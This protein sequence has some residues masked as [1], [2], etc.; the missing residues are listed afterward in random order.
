[1]A[2][3]TQLT[4]MAPALFVPALRQLCAT[5]S[6]PGT[7]TGEMTTAL[8]PKGSAPGALPT[9]FMT[10]GP[11]EESVAAAM[12]SPQAMLAALLTKGLQPTLLTL[13][14][15]LGASK[16]D[17]RDPWVVMAEMN[18]ELARPLDLAAK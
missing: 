13:A 2:T 8:V 12:Q 4:R 6:Q 9:W 16:V 17:P 10:A 5:L 1:V 14:Q 18:L 11:I 15:T 3:Y 7:T